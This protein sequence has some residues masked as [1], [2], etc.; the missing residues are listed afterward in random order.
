[1]RDLKRFQLHKIIYEIFNTS[2]LIF[3]FVCSKSLHKNM[4]IKLATKKAIW[5][6]SSRPSQSHLSC[7]Y[8][9]IMKNAGVV[10]INIA[11]ER[12]VYID[13]ISL[14]F[15]I[16]SS[17]SLDADESKIIKI[18]IVKSVTEILLEL[19][20]RKKR[21]LKYVELHQRS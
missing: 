17:A 18:A 20:N 19:C 3:F 21:D 8:Y 15:A 2:L 7:A 9:N 14:S 1:M 5:H 13:E 6:I 4:L 11:F 12:F 10:L 16:H